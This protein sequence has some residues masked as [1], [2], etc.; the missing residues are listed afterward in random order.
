[1]VLWSDHGRMEH[2][3]IV[4][5][6]DS[7]NRILFDVSVLIACLSQQDEGSCDLLK[8]FPKLLFTQYNISVFFGEE[9]LKE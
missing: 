8:Q 2:Q 7:S 1:M 9:V 3:F 5:C 4:I 6:I